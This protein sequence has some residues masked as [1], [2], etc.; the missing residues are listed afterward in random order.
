MSRA[1]LSSFF[2]LNGFTLH[3]LFRS[4]MVFWTIFLTILEVTFISALVVTYA[5]V[6]SSNYIWKHIRITRFSRKYQY[7]NIFKHFDPENDKHVYYK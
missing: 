5:V 2:Y 3:M 1:K 6:K 4:L 7:L